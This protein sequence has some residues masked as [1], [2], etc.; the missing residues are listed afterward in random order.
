MRRIFINQQEY[1]NKFWTVEVKDLSRII[2]FGKIDTQGRQTTKIFNSH[3]E[4]MKDTEKLIVQK[5]NKGY[6]EISENDEIPQKLELTEEERELSFFWEMIKKSNKKIGANWDEYDV[7][8]HIDCLTKLL[9]KSGKQKIIS[10][11]KS[12]LRIMDK[13]YSAEIAELSII[14]VNSFKKENGKVVFE[15]YISSDGFI[16]FRCWLILQGKAFFDDITTDINAFINGKYSFDIGNTWAEE[17]MYVSNE[18]NMLRNEGADE[19][20]ITD[21]VGEKFPEIPHYDTYKRAINR[22]IL[23]GDE[24]Q[25]AYPQLVKKIIKI[26]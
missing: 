23:G 2:T 4:C 3:L 13:L 16:Y 10:F 5:I 9:S 20:E 22:P 1:S 14:L 26:R 12:F 8:E 11:E 21:Y 15:N 19:Y 24:I 7:Q 18:A 25:A 17:L 6:I